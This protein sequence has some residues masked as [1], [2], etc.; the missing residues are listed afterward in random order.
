[1][2][3]TKKFLTGGL[4]V[5][6][7]FLFMTGCA[8]KK[9]A[10]YKE[11][12]PAAEAEEAKKSAG[13]L[14]LVSVVGLGNSVLVEADGLLQYTVFK[15]SDPPRVAIDMPGV[16]ADIVQGLVPVDNNF[17]TDIKTSVTGEGDNKIARIEVG[18]KSGVNYDVKAGD[19]SLL[20]D[21]SVE[22]YISGVSAPEEIEEE[23]A[24]E[25]ESP[26]E[27]AAPELATEPAV[28]P[29]VEPVAAPAEVIP[30]AENIISVETSFE[31][32]VTVVRLTGDGQFGNYNSFGLD[33]PTR[34][35]LDIWGVSAP[36]IEKEA[37]VSG[38]FIKGLRVGAYPDKTR[39][40]FDSNLQKMPVYTIEKDGRALV[41]RFGADIE[42]ISAQHAVASK[43][44]VPPYDAVEAS[45]P[46]ASAY[47]PP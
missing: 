18:L 21:L 6:A 33:S 34:V 8:A 47:V 7:A 1:M 3:I 29:S 45:A 15:L 27:A 9:P 2:S 35:V 37:S 19:D 5:C 14:T 10:F 38:P 17:I 22:T 13:Q 23:P 32:G 36:A 42:Q 43:P 41:A 26:I 46:I 11:P 40:V 44:Y 12:A 31:R 28:E 20:I 24:A 25:P 39:L 30:D 16:G 4:A